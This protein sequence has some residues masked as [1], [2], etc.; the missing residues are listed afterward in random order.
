MEELHA[1]A[2]RLAPA[3]RRALVGGNAARLYNLT[4]A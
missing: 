3:A 2:A 4:R 1:L